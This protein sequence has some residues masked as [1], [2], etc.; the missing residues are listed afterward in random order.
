M[1]ERLAEVTARRQSID[2]LRQVVDA[3]RSLAAVRQ[4]QA[5]AA[6]PGIR[7]Y[8]GVIAGALARAVSLLEE[9]PARWPATNGT[10]DGHAAL[11]TILFTAEHGFVGGF[12]ERLLAA[13]GEEAGEL[14]IVGSRGQVLAEER[15]IPVGWSAAMA[16]HTDAVLATC[17]LVAGAIDERARSGALRGLQVI[18]ARTGTGSGTIRREALL[19]VDLGRLDGHPNRPAPLTNL[20][21]RRLV[22]RL[23]DEYLFAQIALA[24][25][26]SFAAENAARLSVMV[27]ARQ[28]VDE[29]LAE[30]VAAERRLRQEDITN[31]VIELSAGAFRPAARPRGRA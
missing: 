30:L 25:M 24:A 4:Q 31:E 22:E 17:R 20:E 7:A 14:W 26:E 8:A 1:T 6:L 10:G 2:G 13:A 19:P 21:P 3:M 28:N 18:Y 27:S 15:G 16:T 29:K 23:V 5:G 12:A 9:P 11:L